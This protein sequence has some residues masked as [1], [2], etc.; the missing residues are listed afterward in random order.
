MTE[1]FTQATV[2]TQANVYFDGA[3]VSYTVIT[4][5]DER[6]TI[7]VIFP[8][9]LTFGTAAPERMAIVSGACRVLLPGETEWRDI[10]A[11]QEFSI[12]GDSSF[13]IEVTDTVNYVCHYG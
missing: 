7:G 9:T 2:L 5:E 8:S 12:P 6:V 4:A 13:D 11:G 10:A 3:C 1:Q